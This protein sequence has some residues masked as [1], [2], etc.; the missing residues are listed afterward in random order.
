MAIKNHCTKM[1][2]KSHVFVVYMEIIQ[3]LCSKVCVFRP[4]KQLLK[5]PDVTESLK[6]KKLNFEI[7]IMVISVC[8]SWALDTLT[9]HFVWLL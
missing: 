7:T 2:S 1:F 8:F 4:P 9:I 5:T 3:A 6:E